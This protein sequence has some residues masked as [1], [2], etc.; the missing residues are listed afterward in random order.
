MPHW[1]FVRLIAWWLGRRAWW[2]YNHQTHQH[3]LAGY[4]KPGGN[5]RLVLVRQEQQKC[6]LSDPDPVLERYR[7]WQFSS[8]KRQQLAINISKFCSGWV[9]T[10]QYMWYIARFEPRGA[11]SLLVQPEP[12]P[13]NVQRDCTVGN[14]TK[15]RLYQ[16]YDVTLATINSVFKIPWYAWVGRFW[17]WGKSQV[18]ICCLS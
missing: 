12:E 5:L 14:S 4:V 9:Y 18:D 6:N 13:H 7:I 1:L 3:D 17:N 11:A 8:S 2:A 16:N 15:P 10:V